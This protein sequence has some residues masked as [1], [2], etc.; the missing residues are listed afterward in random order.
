M[1]PNHVALRRLINDLRQEE[2]ACIVV[3]GMRDFKALAC[4]GV[5]KDRII[6]AAQ[7]RYSE[8][9][10]RISIKTKKLIPLFDN[11]QTGRTRL[12]NFIAYFSSNGLPID[13]SY[14]SRTRSAGLSCI[15][16]IKSF[17]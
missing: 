1:V 15:E 2:G 3:E 8:L 10:K 13:Y 7:T 5:P 11:D 16:S 4:L 14:C 6:Q 9:E 12:S 17:Y